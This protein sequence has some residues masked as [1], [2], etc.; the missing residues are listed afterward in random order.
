MSSIDKSPAGAKS[1]QALTSLPCLV[2]TLQLEAENVDVRRSRSKGARVHE[3]GVQTRKG[4]G[5]RGAYGRWA[6]K[7]LHTPRKGSRCRIVSRL[8]GCL[9]NALRIVSELS[10]VLPQRGLSGPLSVPKDSPAFSLYASRKYSCG[11]QVLLVGSP[12]REYPPIKLF[13]SPSSQH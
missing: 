9:D 3:Q 13:H 7:V 8:V 2:L 5:D 11:R 12:V 6:P 4:T 1:A 10:L